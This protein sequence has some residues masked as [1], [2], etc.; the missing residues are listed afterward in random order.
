MNAK[1]IILNAAIGAACGF[2]ILLAFKKPMFC[3][4]AM[5]LMLI[6]GALLGAG[7]APVLH[8]VSLPTG[9]AIGLGA[10]HG[11]VVAVG[12]AAALWVGL[13]QLTSD[14]KI[15]SVLATYEQQFDE[16]ERM[17]D[18][19][20]EGRSEAELEEFRRNTE[21][22]EK[23]LQQAKDEPRVVRTVALWMVVFTA[24]ALCT[25]SGL[26]GGF[27][28]SVIFRRRLRP[29]DAGPGVGDRMRI[30]DETDR[31]WEKHE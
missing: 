19:A 7:L 11:A 20:G 12:T 14:E 24:G 23:L 9:P 3:C 18:E 31:W 17:A 22:L 25:L 10:V 1:T 26:L 4:A 29:R 21:E 5:P 8:G 15:R 28:G 13:Y 16:W 6:L 30:P 27:L 2:L